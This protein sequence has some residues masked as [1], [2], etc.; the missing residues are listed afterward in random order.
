MQHRRFSSAVLITALFTLLAFASAPAQASATQYD[1]P[2]A[3][4]IVY[5]EC[6][7]EFVVLTSGYAHLNTNITSN[8][9]GGSH[10]VV[11][12]NFQ[13]IE[14]RGDTTGATYRFVG[15]EH[16][17]FNTQP[18]AAYTLTSTSH[19]GA[20]SQG[21]TPNAIFQVVS[22]ITINANGDVTAAFSNYR[23]ICQE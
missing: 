2:V 9:N 4:V 11:H 20:V 22:H 10:V 14:G 21:P 6:N 5:N 15:S 18:G 3:G 17:S 1:E 16:Y 7:G 19:R 8:P 13:D 23:I 12:L